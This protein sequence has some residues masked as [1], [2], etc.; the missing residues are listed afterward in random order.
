[1]LVDSSVGQNNNCFVFATTRQCKCALVSNKP[2]RTV[3][4]WHNLL[5]YQYKCALVSNKPMPTVA[6]WHNL[7]SCQCKCALVSNKP[8][9]T[10][11]Q[12]HNSLI[13][14]AN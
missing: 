13:I 1:M 14:L 2:M 8:V 12:W 11:A 6:Q 7:L 9:P 10:V 5:S 4:Q 3:A